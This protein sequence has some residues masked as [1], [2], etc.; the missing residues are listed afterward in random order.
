MP[1]LAMLARKL[2][3]L[4]AGVSTRSQMSIDR[5]SYGAIKTIKAC[6]NSYAG[7]VEA[8]SPK[9]RVEAPLCAQMYSS[10]PPSSLW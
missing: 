9:R 10:L 4:F 8:R 1:R 5:K 7:L 3:L 2:F 6:D